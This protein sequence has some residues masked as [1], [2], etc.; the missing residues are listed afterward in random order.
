MWTTEQEVAAIAREMQTGIRE[1]G[2]FVDEHQGWAVILEEA[3]EA[4]AE[5]DNMLAAVNAMKRAVFQD[6]SG[7]TYTKRDMLEMMQTAAMAAKYMESFKWEGRE[8]ETD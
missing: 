4:Q 5:Q 7:F 8:D 6:N 2:L 3:E 1:H